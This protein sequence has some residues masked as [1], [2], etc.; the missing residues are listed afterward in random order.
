[1]S[2]D[3][4]VAPEPDEENRVIERL[5]EVAVDPSR[6]EALLDHWEAMIA[7]QRAGA[8]R[9]QIPMSGLTLL[10]GHVERA[11]QVL[12]R[13]LSMD[14][15]QGPQAV[16]DQI[17]RSAAFA[18]DR[19]L[20][21]I[22]ANDSATSLLGVLKGAKLSNLQLGDGDVDQLSHHIGRLL[23]ANDDEPAVLRGRTANSERLIVFHLRAV[24]GDGE[25]TPAESD[26]VRA[27]T[28]GRTL[29][30]IAQERGRSI[31]TIRAQLKSVMAK[32][33]TRSQTEL[34]RLTLSTMEI[35]QFTEAASDAAE[36]VSQGYEQLEPRTFHTVSL[37]DGRRMDYLI[38]GDPA[39]APLVYSP[40][41]YGL[42]RWPA[43]AEA[44]AKKRGIKVIVP[45]RAGYGKSTPLPKR[46]PYVPQL[47]DDL[48]AM[49]DDA[50]V[51]SAPFIALGGDTHIITHFNSLHPERISALIAC[52]GVLPLTQSEQ[53]DFCRSWLRLVL[54][55][56]NDWANEGSCMPST[57]NPKP[58]CA[59]LQM[60]KSTKPWWSDQMSASA[61]HTA[62]M[63][64]SLVR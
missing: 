9:G 13:V 45:V 23:N 8:G 22:A 20:G 25:F 18:V 15:P 24:R 62:P 28:E 61:I 14:Q 5:Y 57:V 3:K 11:D 50:G 7:P 47:C 48:A 44:E 55:W 51:S 49:M 60:Q 64:P 32:T 36:D 52:A 17:G 12:D 41:D 35:A 34:V 56:P 4:P 59:P 33:E 21:I 2:T 27:L 6:Y 40:L 19:S 10:T 38:L 54:H 1:M 37:S 16:L 43:S 39:G 63:T 31:D 26:V 29:Q 30:Q 53:Y 46:V 42:I 58:T